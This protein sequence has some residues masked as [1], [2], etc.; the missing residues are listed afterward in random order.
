MAV[1]VLHI[2]GQLG[3]GGCEKQL[4][5]ICRRMDRGRFDLGV[6]YYA[7]ME[8]D[9][10]EDFRRAGVSV[11]F[12]D[13][14][15]VGPWRFF[16]ALRR[17]IREF[18]PD[19]IHC[20]QYSPNCWGRLAAAGC[21]YG[22][23]ICGERTATRLPRPLRLFEYVFGRRTLWTANTSA[24][25]DA[26]VRFA[27]CSRSRIRVLHNAVEVPALDRAA[28]RRS[29][30]DEL[31]LAPDAP[32]VLAVGRL[33]EAKNYPMFL[34]V[35][36]RVAA[37]RPDA[38]FAVAGDGPLADELRAL[39]A[40][41][42]LG[43]SLRMLGLRSDVPLLMAAADVFCLCSRWEG[44]PNVLVEAMAS[45]LPAVTTSFA[46]VR[47]IVDDGPDRIARAVDIDDDEAMA[48]HVAELLADPVAGA[49]LADAACVSVRYRF[50]W[51]RLI[52]DLERLYADFLAGI[53]EDRRE[54]RDADG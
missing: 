52:R 6:A 37:R 49:A 17:F 43:D 38:V 5:E 27:G 30:R 40:E 12:T 14:A 10:V 22:R 32:L 24:V 33:H 9:L 7:R 50:S 48:G 46:G 23:Y 45:R 16:L 28:A 31:G 41:M 19:V 54:V 47:E 39:H 51:D 20:W 13:K 3:V 36:R 44:F 2:I 15:A 26:L 42:K 25:A 53:V 29:V 8:N 1:R 35:A 4:L 34:R 11:W 18:C 21:G